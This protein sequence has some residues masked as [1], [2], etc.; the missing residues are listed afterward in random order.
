[1]KV[2]LG[3]LPMTHLLLGI[4]GKLSVPAGLLIVAFII[5]CN[6]ED[7]GLGCRF[8]LSLLSA[9]HAFAFNMHGIAYVFFLYGI[10][11]GMRESHAF[12]SPMRYRLS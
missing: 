10:A 7:K 11:L 6:L 3:G 1:M 12:P 8:A 9:W 4:L 5:G 2:I